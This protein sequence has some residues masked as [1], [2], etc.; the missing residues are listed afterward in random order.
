M[1]TLSR[2]AITE[3]KLLPSWW[4]SSGLIEAARIGQHGVD[5]GV[6][7]AEAV[8]F[9]ALLLSNAMFFQL[10][11][12]W[13]AQAC[14]KRGYSGLVGET[15][16][17]RRRRTARPGR[18]AT[19][20][21][22]V[23]LL[24][25]KDLTLFCRDIT[26]WSQFVIFAGLMGLYFLNLRAFQYN[27][28]YA[29]MIGYLNLAVVGLILSTF[30]TR[31]VFPMI[32][33]EGRRFWILGLLPVRRD[34]IV[35][36]KFLFAIVGS[37]PPCAALVLLSD[38]MLGLRWP[39]IVQHEICCAVLCVGLAGISVGLGARI[40][41]FRESSPAKIS[42]GFGGTLCLVVSSLYIV[43][44][45][46]AAAVPTHAQIFAQSFEPTIPSPPIA[47]VLRQTL[48]WLGS[49]QGTAASMLF[50]LA[51]GAVATAVPLRAGL[52]AFRRLEP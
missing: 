51:L 15:R 40:P 10:V 45:V 6:A 26:Q 49:D 46:L 35:W 14:Y 41:E 9:L 52:R 1:Q 43:S 39:L 16:S 48:G 21:R 34:E 2:L 20:G 19:T 12:G 47:P 23:L 3:Q 25:A 22:P 32:S 11:A 29:A 42:S 31:F 28:V 37:L 38:S 13:V 5:S 17:P 36:S 30:T 50:V 8:K 44:V 24:L 4:L 7:A 27:S 18:L 33:L